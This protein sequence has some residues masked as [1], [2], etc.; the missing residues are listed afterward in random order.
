MSSFRAGIQ[1]IEDNI[2]I[3]FVADCIRM[4]ADNRVD[5]CAFEKE[6]RM[7]AVYIGL[8]RKYKFVR[9]SRAR[10]PYLG[11]MFDA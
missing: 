8:S 7:E 9:H 5:D 6:C 4:H 1:H 3:M 11:T 10:A 2:C